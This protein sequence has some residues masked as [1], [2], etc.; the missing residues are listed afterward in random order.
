MMGEELVGLII[1]VF[2]AAYAL[3][4]SGYVVGHIYEH[5]KQKKKK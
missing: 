3:Y 1:F 5:L 4:W 2:V